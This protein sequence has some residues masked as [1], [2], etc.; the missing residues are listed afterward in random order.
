MT[1]P[2]LVDVRSSTY[3]MYFLLP[4][5]YK[6]NIPQPL[7]NEIEPVI[8]PK[9]KYAAVKRFVGFLT[10]DF[11]RPNIDALKKS[12][13][14]TPYQ[15]AASHDLS[16]MAAYNAPFRIVDRCWLGNI[17]PHC[18]SVGSGRARHRVEEGSDTILSI[19]A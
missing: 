8:L 3:T 2:V 15:T 17:L 10:D 13:Q 19:N 18:G 9:H 7:S 6:N 5:E 12:L 11:I 16:T 14:G 4:K 1:T